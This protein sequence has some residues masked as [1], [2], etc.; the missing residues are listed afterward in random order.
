MHIFKN[1]R[2]YLFAPI[3]IGFFVAFLA[4][5]FG[6]VED[7]SR[8]S[9]SSGFVGSARPNPPPEAGS[10]L[11]VETGLPNGNW[12]GELAYTESG[13][14]S[15]MVEYFVR[16]Q[17]DTYWTETFSNEYTGLSRDI[18]VY[19]EPGSAD[20]MHVQ[21][22]LFGECIAVGNELTCSSTPEQRFQIAR[23][24]VFYEHALVWAESGSLEGT[25]YERSG[26]LYFY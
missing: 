10:E 6:C 22:E 9:Q 14:P 1:N 19:S 18:L 15:R 7:P 13:T 8:P 12:I 20:W 3:S 16:F 25:S 4:A 5:S 23:K 2:R 21:G 24:L 17:D 11:I 26:V